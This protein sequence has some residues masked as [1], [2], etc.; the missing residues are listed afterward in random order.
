MK[1]H[2][3]LACAILVVAAPLKADWYQF[4]GPGASGV[5]A[6]AELP[7]E[8]DE[9]SIAWKAP[10]RGRGLSSPIVVGD[11]VFLTGCDGPRQDHLLV[12]AF[13]AKTG[14]QLWEREFWATGRTAAHPKTSVAAPTPATD[15]KH[16]VA[17]YSSNDVACLDLEGN[18]LWYRGLTHDYPNASNSLGMSSS[19]VIVDGIAVC[20]VENDTE[21][22]TFGLDLETGETVWKLDRPKAANWTSPIGYTMPNT[23]KKVVLLQSSEGISAIDP[24][25][26]NELWSYQDGASTIPSSTSVGSRIYI[27]SNGITVIEPGKSDPETPEIIWQQGSLSPSTASPV[28]YRGRVYVLNRAGVLTGADTESGERVLQLR[29]KGPFSGTPVIAGDS[30]YVVN[31]QGLIQVVSLKPDAEEI[32][33][34]FELG[35]TILSTPAISGNA[36]YVR[37][38]GHLWKIAK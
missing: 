8:I 1:I 2:C 22:Y 11:Q 10:L 27:P 7:V 19:V 23:D 9:E 6:D 15:G 34:T 5:A 21:S 24:Q 38:D 26:G 13:D 18:L 37:S 28:I 3:L 36:M 25:T 16:I 20:P 32:V 33:S 31:E 17:F 35:E 29:T 4:R 14:D 30:L 12:W